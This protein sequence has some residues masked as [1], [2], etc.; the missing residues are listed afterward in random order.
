MPQRKKAAKRTLRPP[1][2][3]VLHQGGA[4]AVPVALT[5]LRAAKPVTRIEDLLK[6]TGLSKLINKELKK[7]K[8][9]KSI[10]K[11]VSVVSKFLKTLGFGAA[12][13][14]TI[15]KYHMSQYQPVV[16]RPVKF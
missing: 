9:G 12:D 16:A 1:T 8:I 4:I 10:A 14:Q 11:G 5:A 2:Q 13:A 15:A 6:S 3:L 7:S